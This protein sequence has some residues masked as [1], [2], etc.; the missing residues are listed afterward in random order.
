MSRIHYDYQALMGE[1]TLVP[2]ILHQNNI[3][4]NRDGSY[5]KEIYILFI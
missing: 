1:S 2:G 4:K 5:V 3:E